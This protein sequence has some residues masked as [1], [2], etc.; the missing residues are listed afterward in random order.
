MNAVI[1]KEELVSK[2]AICDK[3]KGIGQTGDINAKLIPGKSD[4]DLF[5][6][7]SSVPLKEER[8]ALYTSLQTDCFTSQMEVCQ[9]GL[10]G[11]GDILIVDGIDVMPMYFT[12]KEM[13]EYLDEVL[14]CRRLDKDGRFYPVGRL[15]SVA[16]INVLYEESDTWTALVS[17]VNRKPDSFFKAWFESEIYQVLDEE[18]LGRAVLHKEVLFFHQVLENAL[19]HLL[20]ALFAVNNCYFPSRK[21][22]QVAINNFQYKPNNCFARLVTIVS[23]GA[24]SETIEEAI[25]ELRNMTFEIAEQGRYHFSSEVDL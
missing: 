18:D 24:N 13:E 4:I 2:L 12:V 11:Y 22:T 8:E 10:W 19:D 9:G 17:R 14:Q 5:V 15:A 1:L 21:R 16:S 25:H 3:V 7:C 20:Q 6:L 23:N